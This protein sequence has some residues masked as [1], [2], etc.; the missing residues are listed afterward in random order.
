[1]HLKDKF[2][3]AEAMTPADWE[4]HFEQNIATNWEQLPKGSHEAAKAMATKLERLAQQP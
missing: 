2:D 4:A 3:R 1:L